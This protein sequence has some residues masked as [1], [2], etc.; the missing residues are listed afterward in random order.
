MSTSD[1]LAKK[2]NTCPTNGLRARPIMCMTGMK[3]AAMIDAE[4]GNEFV[5][6]F[7]LVI[8]N[9]HFLSLYNFTDLM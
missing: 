7:Y 3:T 6:E 5:H 1:S 9:I 4:W 8:R 2:R